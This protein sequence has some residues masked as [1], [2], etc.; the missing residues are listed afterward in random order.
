VEVPRVA[1]EKLSADRVG[2]PSEQVRARV[3]AARGRQQARF[4]AKGLTCNADMGPSELRRHCQVDE[5]GRRLLRTA[6][7]QMQLTARGYH[8]VLKLGRTI[9][10]LAGEERLA[11]QHLAE[12]LQYRAVVG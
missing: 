11:P 8:R 3:E 6:M 2:E 10:D 12:A 1:I 5:T 7:T 9:A 4:G